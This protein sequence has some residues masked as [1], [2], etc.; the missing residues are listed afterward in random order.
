MLKTIQM[1]ILNQVSNQ[2]HKLKIDTI[3]KHNQFINN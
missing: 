2:P 1:I 3:W